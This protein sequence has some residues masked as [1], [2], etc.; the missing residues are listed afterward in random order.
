MKRLAKQKVAFFALV[1]LIIG[2]VVT[3]IRVTWSKKPED[4]LIQAI[5]LVYDAPNQAVTAAL[6]P[7]LEPEMELIPIGPN[8][9][10]I[11]EEEYLLR[12]QTLYGAYVAEEY[13]GEFTTKYG[14]MLQH[15][16]DQTGF[17]FSIADVSITQNKNRYDYALTLN[18]SGGNDNH[19]EIELSGSARLNGESKV[20][21]L[22][23]HGLQE[24]FKVVGLR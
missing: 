16:A 7:P 22:N 19:T 23:P 20:E 5:H 1:L 9:A 24:L 10:Q 8:V 6:I 3:V 14:L 21:N 15:I 12:I 18:C 11:P 4:A 13:L 17:A 2:A